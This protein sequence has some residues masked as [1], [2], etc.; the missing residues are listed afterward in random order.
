MLLGF[1]LFDR[2]LDKK[3]RVLGCTHET[4]EVRQLPSSLGATLFLQCKCGYQA[5]LRELR[6]L[7]DGTF[8]LMQGKT[9]DEAQDA[10]LKAYH[11]HPKP[12]SLS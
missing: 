7:R 5:H 11:E 1:W 8:W 6:P 9:W 12:K 2:S 3:K 4:L 10:Y